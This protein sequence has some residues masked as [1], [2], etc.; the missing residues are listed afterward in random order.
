MKGKTPV[1]TVEMKS[2]GAAQSQLATSGGR[3]IWGITGK[4]ISAVLGI[5]ILTMGV[6][7]FIFT[8]GYRSSLQR[9]MIAKAA[10]FSAFADEVKAN[11]S[12][13]HEQAA[14][15][16]GSLRTELAD[17]LARGRSYR[18][19][20]FYNAIPIVSAWT[21]AARVAKAE[22]LDFKVVA[23]DPRNPDHKLDP[24]SFRARMLDDLMAQAKRGGDTFLARTDSDT[25]TLRAMRAIRLS[26]DCLYC[27]GQ[28]G[29]AGDINKDGKDALGF[30]MESWNAGDFHGAFELALPLEI[31]DRQVIMFFVHSLI[32]SLPIAI[33]AGVFFFLLVRRLVGRPIQMLLGR[34]GEAA[35]GDLSARMETDR[36][37]EIGLLA[38]GYNTFLGNL[39]RMIR[40]IAGKAGTLAS[41]SGELTSVSGQMTSGARD[42]SGRAHTV[43]AAA[44]QASA[45][46]A[47]VAASMEQMSASLTTVAAATEQMS[48]TVGEIASNSEKARTISIEATGQAEAISTM[49]KE[50][51]RG[52][53][54]IGKV[55]ETITS[56]SA[57][58]NLLALNATIE[59]ARAGA[60]GKGFAVVANEIKELAQQTASATEDIKGRIAGIQASTGG[61]IGDIESISRVIRDVGE[62][63]STIAAAIEEQSVVTRDVATNIAQASMGVRD[64]NE[65][66]AQTATVSQS[67]A[68]DIA[69]VEMTIHEISDGGAQIQSSASD[70]SS[71]AGELESMV[72]RFKLD[73]S[74]GS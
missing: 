61:A 4:M 29:S 56:I 13:Q 22:K 9:E 42:M 36:D 26:S 28:R 17:I 16:V 32:W 34:F 52:A 15:D 74:S 65:R 14:F 59:A 18:E 1:G 31:I 19:S 10:A 30:R 54:E 70:L 41:S 63:V 62:I 71:L 68:Q 37:D 27:H 39:R 12:R 57:Q 24:G 5:L 49:M 6:N 8:Q 69:Q 46:T 50:L 35:Q 58:T 43:A 72:G 55:T 67:I 33:I 38:T 53:H 51:G 20:R 48:A 7:Y 3:R 73:D 25:N 44:E 66:I 60:A 47:S 45:N 21:V 64:S 40:D 11:V 2:E 23:K